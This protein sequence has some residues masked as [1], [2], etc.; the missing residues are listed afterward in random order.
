[1]LKVNI[2]KKLNKFNLEFN[3]EKDKDIIGLI[4]SSG[5][6]KSMTLKCIAGIEKPDKGQIILNDRILFDSEKKINVKTKDRHIAYLFQNYA[7]FPNMTVWK[8]IFISVNKKYSNIEK[9]DKVKNMIQ[10]L[11]LSGLENKYPD[12]LSGGQ[13]QRVALARIVVNE[14]EYLLLDE[15]FSAIDAF[16]KWN[17]AKELKKTIKFF[18]KG[19]L[20]VSHN[21]NEVYYIC[22]R[23]IIMANGEVVEEGNIKE[24]IENPKTEA[25]KKI[26]M[27]SDISR[28]E[29]DEMDNKN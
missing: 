29:L 19:T 27:F 14:P 18:D 4:G 28:K 21:I 23:S 7:L 17:L 3:F 8:N 26:V 5:S 15:P 9:Q 11:E 25:C 12:E 13:Q 20:F 24:I 6:G 16:L 22:K 1:M 10:S 2:K